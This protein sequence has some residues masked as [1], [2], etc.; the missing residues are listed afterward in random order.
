MRLLPSSANADARRLLLAR[1]LRGL[2]DGWMSVLL[3]IYLLE[4][5]YEAH[6]AGLMASAALLGSAL[7]TMAVGFLPL[8]WGRRAL[9]VAASA[10]MF[11]TGLAAAGFEA[12]VPLLIVA[13]LGTLNLSAGDTSVFQPLE[14]ALLPDTAS[15]AHRT[16]LF[17]R[18]A[19]LGSA[20]GAA[21][22]LGGGV[23]DWMVAQGIADKLGAMQAM[24]ALYA[25]A[26]IAAGLIYAR[27]DTGDRPAPG[28]PLPRLGPSRGIVIKLSLLFAV[29]SFGSSLVV[30]SLVSLWFYDR[31]GLSLTEISAVFFWSGLASALSLL[32]A[33]PVARRIGL[34]NTM[35]FTHLPANI[36]LAAMPFFEDPAIVI[37][38]FLARNLLSQMDVPT[39]ASYIA[40]VVR[41]EERAAA[42]SVTLLPRSLV[43]AMG[44][45]LGGALFALAPF[46][47]PFLIAG[48]LK[49]GYDV[50]LYCMFRAI[51]PPEER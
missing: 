50:A 4:L 39:R 44:P 43:A 21:G 34:V 20:A 47:W 14:Q 23:P 37:G 49:A 7:L 1:T 46:A 27:L 51:K 16:A 33:A 26:G 19:F 42:A 5:G 30:Q 15:D 8:P 25:A 35:A 48:V 11:A 24:F 40:A 45:S 9:L 36:F 3:P 29:D 18:Y 2:A 10:L 12:F 32:L 6:H 41:P 13:F 28:T 38:L 22:A 17:G 31:L